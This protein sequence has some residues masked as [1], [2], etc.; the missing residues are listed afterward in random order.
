[1]INEAMPGYVKIGLTNDINRRI[2]GHIFPRPYN[3]VPHS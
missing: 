2:K 1:M 3:Y